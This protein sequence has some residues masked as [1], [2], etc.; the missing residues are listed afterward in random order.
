[1]RATRGGGR[2]GRGLPISKSLIELPGGEMFVS[3]QLNEGSTFSI[4][5]P[6]DPPSTK[7]KGDTD[8]LPRIVVAASDDEDTVNLEEQ[9]ANGATNGKKQQPESESRRTSILPAMLPAKRQVLIIEDNPD[10]V[11]QFRRMIQ[12]EGFDVFAAS[13]PLEAEAMAS[14]LRPSVIVMD[15]DFAGGAGWD[16]L[17]KSK[18]RDNTFEIRVIVVTLSNQEAGAREAGAFAFL[19]HPI[20]PDDLIAAVLQAEQESNTER[21]LI[22][23]AQPDSARLLKQLL[24]EHGR[25]RVFAAHNGS[26]G[27]SMVAR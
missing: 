16:I 4:T 24:D 5:V 15:V 2:T 10:R 8:K 6:L 9:S 21:I 18:G 3:P 20:V 25:Y 1:A 13:I 17:Q 7:R 23:D 19:Q 14:G 12:R 22:I 27:V 11:D 26:E